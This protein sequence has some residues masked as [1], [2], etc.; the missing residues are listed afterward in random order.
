MTIAGRLED[1]LKFY[2]EA[3][4]Q[5]GNHTVALLNTARL[6]KKLKFNDKAESLYQRLVTR[7][8]SKYF[9]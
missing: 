5:D 7:S 6:M 3:L 1:A 2:Q 8:F 4:Q 9:Y